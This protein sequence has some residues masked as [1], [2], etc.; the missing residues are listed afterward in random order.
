[1]V[2]IDDPQ[3]VEGRRIKRIITLTD[4]AMASSGNYRKFRVDSLTGKKYVH[5]ID[6]RTGYTRDASVLAVSVLA[7]TCME[8]DGFATAFMAMDLE[9]SRRILE[10]DP[11]LEG[12]IIYLN[13]AGETLEYTTPG[14]EAVLQEGP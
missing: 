3:V 14:F 9:D 11:K 1:M 7:E 5:T 4:R 10:A 12:Y 2:G 8:A 13:D 6:P